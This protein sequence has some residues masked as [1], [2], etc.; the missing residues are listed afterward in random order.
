MDF[1]SKILSDLVNQFTKLPGIGKRTAIRMALYLLKMPADDVEKMG[2][3]LLKLKTDIRY[4]NKC[5]NISENETC[6]ICN[7]SGRDRNLVCVVEDVRDVIAIENTVQYK[8]H[9]HV[10]GGVISPIDGISPENLNIGS[11]L[12]RVKKDHPAEL[13]FALRATIEGDT[14]MLFITRQLEDE[15]IKFSA[16]ARGISIGTDLEFADE[17]TLGRSIQNRTPYAI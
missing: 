5:H 11:L 17:I 6:D 16:I 1:P 14:T 15:N 3:L 13:V 10:L 8:G 4:C 12:D 7:D 2:T 9:Y